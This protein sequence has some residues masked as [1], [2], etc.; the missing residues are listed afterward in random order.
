[1]SSDDEIEFALEILREIVK[2][3]M[4]TLDELLEEN[5]TNQDIW[6]NDFCR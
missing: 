1:V 5:N 2:P 3:S 4:D 6:R